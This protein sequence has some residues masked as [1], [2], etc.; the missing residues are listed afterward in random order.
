M[1]LGAGALANAL[2][3]ISSSPCS[4]CCW[5]AAANKTEICVAERPRFVSVGWEECVLWRLS[6]LT[7]T[8]DPSNE[9]ICI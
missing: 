6:Q 4:F 2:S 1:A 9:K 5:A 7:R 3:A 8:E